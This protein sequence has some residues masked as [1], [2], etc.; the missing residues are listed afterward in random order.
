MKRKKAMLLFTGITTLILLFGFTA[1][2]ADRAKPRKSATLHRKGCVF[3]TV[4][5]EQSSTHD[6]VYKT[7]EKVTA[8]M[9][10]GLR[11]IAAAQNENGG[12]GA[13]SHSRQDVRDPNAVAS[14]PATTSMVTM[15]LLRSGNTLTSGEFAPRVNR[16]IHYLLNAVETSPAK[17]PTITTVIDTQIQIKLGQNIDVILAAQCLSNALDYVQHDAELKNRIKRALDSCVTRIQ[18]NQNEDGSTQG[19]GWAGVLQSALANNAIEM[20]QAKGA[21]VDL[22]SL[23]K[24]RDYQ[25]GNYEAKTGGVKTEMGAGVVLYSVTGSARASAKEARQVKEELEKAK[26]SGKIP[27]QAPVSVETLEELG[28]T[29]DDAMKYTTAYEVYESAKIQAQRDDVMDGFGSNGGEE[30]VSYLQTGESM[31]INKDTAWQNWF[32]NISGKLLS[33]Q[34]DNGSW[35]GHHCI[36]SPVFCTATCLLILSVNNDIDKLSSIGEK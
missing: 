19:A 29:R 8:S 3:Q 4:F 17:S 35:S 33:I 31:I 21:V 9:N 7:P 22:K 28:Y 34:N 16:A 26:K 20:A 12:W 24:S 25:K 18:K 1:Q 14:D 10:R 27:P 15:A 36:T 6:D 5:G 2:H 11:W 32:D 13:G 30:F 23:D